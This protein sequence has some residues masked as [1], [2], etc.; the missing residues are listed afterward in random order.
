VQVYKDS[1]GTKWKA[2]RFI[3][4]KF[5]LIDAYWNIG[6]LEHLQILYK[7]SKAIEFCIIICKNQF[8]ELCLISV[9]QNGNALKYVKYQTREICLKISD[10]YYNSKNQSSEV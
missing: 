7:S 3:I 10:A 2:D 5:K 4:E 9:M 6:T 1:Y 8:T